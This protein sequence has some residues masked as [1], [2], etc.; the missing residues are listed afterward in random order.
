MPKP[1]WYRFKYIA[2]V[3][4]LDEPVIAINFMRF[5]KRMKFEYRMPFP[6]ETLDDYVD[7]LFKVMEDNTPQGRYFGTPSDKDT[8]VFGYFSLP[9]KRSI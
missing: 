7:Y 9:D 3:G 2:S 6:A 1:S 5:L 8:D 4:S